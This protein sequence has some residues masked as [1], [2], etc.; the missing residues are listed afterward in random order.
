MKEENTIPVEDR[1]SIYGAS[2]A[3]RWRQCPGSVKAIANAKAEGKVP[4]DNSSPEADEGTIA[5]Q[6]SE[7]VLTGKHTIE[8]LPDEF[9]THLVGHIK[10]CQGL[11]ESALALGGLVFNEKAVPLFYRPE[12]YGKLDFATVIPADKLKEHPYGLIDFV[13]LKYGVGVKVDAEDND[14]QAIYLLSLIQWLEDEEAII[15]SDKATVRLAINQP[16]HY[17]YTG[18]PEVWETTIRDVKDMGIDIQEDYKT[19]RDGG[20]EE[21]N[22]SAS[23]CQFCDIKGICTANGRSSFDPLIDFEDPQTPAFKV[24]EDTATFTQEQ[25]AFIIQNGSRIKKMVK[26]VE[27]HERARLEDGGEP[28]LMKLVDAGT[29]GPKKWVDEKAAETFLKNQL[30]LEERYSPRKIIT[31]PQAFAK[32][33]PLKDDLSTIAKAKIGLL[34]EEEA[35]KSKTECLFH[36]E[37]NRH[38]LV[39]IDDERPAVQFKSIDDEFETDEQSG[40]AELD[41][42]M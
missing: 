6:W 21:L 29:L 40:D 10:H 25:I 38:A 33:K 35:K 3:K 26:D 39:G 20:V 11:A 5:H 14:Q 22:P 18:E 19:A 4:K 1:H 28:G 23:A 13:D 8:E 37:P 12:D 27:D 34:T 17:L 16:R 7:D 2:G 36:R 30:P 41:D 24:S 15:F 32:L 9:R 31:A 42:L